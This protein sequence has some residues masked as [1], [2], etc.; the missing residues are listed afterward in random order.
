MEH[1]VRV[2]MRVEL[3]EGVPCCGDG[4]MVRLSCPSSLLSLQGSA[5]SSCQQTV[6]EPYPFE[7]D[8]LGGEQS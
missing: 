6:E 8:D 3:V 5:C 2:P 7:V 1:H 4:C